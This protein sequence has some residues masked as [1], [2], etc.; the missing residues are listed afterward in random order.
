[1]EVKKV[2]GDEYKS[3]R[4]GQI[5]IIDAPTGSGKTT[6]VEEIFKNFALHSGKRILYCTN[7][8]LLKN[9]MQER[10][11]ARILE[12]EMRPKPFW[13]TFWR[14]EHGN[15]VIVTYQQIEAAVLH[16]NVQAIN[17]LSSFDI[18]IVDEAHYFVTDSNFNPN[19]IV[20]FDF[21]I[22]NYK[23]RQMIFMSAT[24]RNFYGILLNFLSRRDSCGDLY[25]KN[26]FTEYKKY[27]VEADYSGI[28]FDCVM[29][30]DEIAEKITAIPKDKKILI[31]VSSIREG[32][33]IE[34]ILNTVLPHNETFLLTSNSVKSEKGEKVRD[35]LVMKQKFSQRVLIAT[36][37][38]DTGVNII[39]DDVQYIFL[40]QNNEEETIQMLGRRRRKPGQS[41]YVC[42]HARSQV[43]F[44]KLYQ[45]YKYEWQYIC[46]V[47][48][49]ERMNRVYFDVLIAKE[50]YSAEKAEIL[51][52]FI[53]MNTYVNASYRYFV[54]GLSVDRILQQMEEFATIIAEFEDKE[55]L[56]YLLY[57]GRWFGF[58]EDV[59]KFK[60]P[61]TYLEQITEFV[62]TKLN[63]WMTVEEFNLFRS[64]L[65]P[66]LHQ[67][68][69][70]MFPKM[71]ENAKWQKLNDFF[72]KNELPFT[73]KMQPKKKGAE[74]SYIIQN[75]YG[76]LI[77]V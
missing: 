77:S 6:F 72:A 31:F 33:E 10:Q 43:Y 65:M 47:C 15:Y 49:Q 21:L 38:L 1:M 74:R 39:D 63:Y 48:N 70:K 16:N 8:I 35:E 14:G 27:D 60:I 58:G 51:K 37:L 62:G 76:G 7:R 4:E 9:Q 19:T 30:N 42:L 26:M 22:S 20:S 3:W 40:F 2:I 29:K 11:N 64:S 34:K 32:K 71:T 12:E 59:L 56:A 53:G 50:F 25:V 13:Q 17:F 75:L 5:I 68:D 41:L 54:N 18:A 73:I 55:S 66:L 61:K 46:Y 36:A 23:N 69:G 45:K 24:M 57:Q 67:A 28:E 52:K 44:K